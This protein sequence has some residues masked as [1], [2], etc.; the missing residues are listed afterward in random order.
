LG[1]LEFVIRM[2]T[3]IKVESVTPLDTYCQQP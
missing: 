1:T 2:G 3:T